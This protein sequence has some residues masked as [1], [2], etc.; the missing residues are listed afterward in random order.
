MSAPPPQ[1]SVQLADEFSLDR[2]AIDRTRHRETYK[3]VPDVPPSA[4]F[5]PRPAPVNDYVL[6]DS[7]KLMGDLPDGYAQTI[8]ADAAH[9]PAVALRASSH[10][11]T[12][13]GSSYMSTGRRT[14]IREGLRVAGPNGVLLYVHRY[15]L[16]DRPAGRWSR[17][18]SGVPS[19][20]RSSSG[21][22]WP[23]KTRPLLP[24]AG[25]QGSIGPSTCSPAIAG[26]FPSTSGTRSEIGEMSGVWE[27]ISR[28]KRRWKCLINW[29]TV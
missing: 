6:G 17:P 3:D 18:H 12:M 15:D 1:S 19:Q 5:S 10:V 9:V 26:A 7:L 22:P 8:V 14:I 29:P 20:S 21:M 2:R 11:R 4:A 28:M 24:P 25:C 13:P 16:A 27:L 23:K